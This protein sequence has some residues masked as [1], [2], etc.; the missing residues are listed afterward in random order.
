MKRILFFIL[1]ASIAFS[2]NKDYYTSIPN[3]PVY[4]ELQLATRDYELNANLAYKIITQPRIAVEKT[5]FGGILVINGM[6]EAPINLYAY[7]LACP[8]EAQS[9]VRVVPDKSGITATCP[10][11]GAVFSIASGTGAPQSGSKYY[12]KSYRVVGN[13][14]QYTVYN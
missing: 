4:V 14:T 8:V 12:L 5:G 11:C 13:G 9:N 2:C 3:Y 10:K 7:D 1:F 6:G